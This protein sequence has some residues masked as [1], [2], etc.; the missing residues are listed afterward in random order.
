MLQ[1]VAMTGSVGTVVDV[2]V[3]VVGVGWPTGR[4]PFGTGTVVVV[5]DAGGGDVGPV[6]APRP[7]RPG[8]VVVVVV[9]VDV[10]GAVVDV[11]AGP[12][13]PAGTV[14]VVATGAVVVVVELVVGPGAGADAVGV[15]VF[16]AITTASTVARP[17][18]ADGDPPIDLATTA[19]LIV[20]H[21][22]SAPAA[23]VA[24]VRRPAGRPS[25]PPL[26]RDSC[27]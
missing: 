10:V 1:S 17:G 11:V 4:P 16:F 2:V 21:T 26:V 13:P 27:P 14:V 12:P 22:I 6:A 9:V 3:V 24:A 19:P 15:P 7:G 23:I 25:G 18:W 8:C 20:L 5:V